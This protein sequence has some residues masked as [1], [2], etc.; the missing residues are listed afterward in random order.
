M[1]PG[2]R[3]IDFTIF[4]EILYEKMGW[5]T[6]S[7]VRRRKP[8]IHEWDDGKPGSTSE[9][10]EDRDPFTHHWCTMMNHWRT[11]DAPATH[12]DEPLTHH[13]RTRSQRPGARGQEPEARGPWPLA[14]GLWLLASGFWC[15]N[16][17]SMVHH[18]ASQVRQL[19]VS[20]S[21]WCING[22]WMDPGLPSSHSWIPVF[23]RLTRGSRVS[24]VSLV[25]PYSSPFFRKEFPEK[26]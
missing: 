9:T 25:I 24:V 19:C 11:I 5:N 21:S 13:C 26:S 22:A 17:A 4:P 14:P 7:R 10:T 18:G 6:G 2:V 1:V 8:G 12:H 15:D 16:G 23:R 20:G 3:K